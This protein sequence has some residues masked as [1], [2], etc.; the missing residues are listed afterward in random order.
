MPHAGQ[1]SRPLNVYSLM[2]YTFTLLLA[3]L[4]IPL[5]A[6]LNTELVGSL[7]YDVDVNDVWGYVAPDGTE[8]ALLGLYDG[9]A[10]IS[11]ADPADPVEVD[12]LQGQDSNWRD[13]KTY[14]DYAYVVADEGDAGLTVVDLRSL[15]DSISYTTQQ[16]T[17]PG[18]SRAFVRAH[19]LYIDQERG[20]LFTAGGDRNLNDGGILIFDVAANPLAPP[21]VAV[22]PDTYAH[23]VYVQ[24]G[25]MYASEIYRGR[26]AL[27]DVTDLGLVT[28]LG[29][30]LT[31]FSFTH[32]AWTTA[33]GRTVFTTDERANASVAAFD[34][35]NYG[36]IRLL[37]EYR[38]L[39]SLN[40]RTIPH[41][42][43][44]IDDF[45]S[46]S[47]YTDGLRVVD[48]SDPANLIEVAN[49]DT[50]PGADGGFNGAWGAYP[51]LPSGLTL[52]SDRATGL[53]VIDVAYQ[54]AARLVGT[55]TNAVT[56]APING[57]RVVILDAYLNEGYTD[58]LGSFA[59]GVVL[60]DTSRVRQDAPLVE[61]PR[62][63][64]RVRVTAPGFFADTV[65]VR[66]VSGQ[67][68]EQS[69]AL[70]PQILAATTLTLRDR[71]SDAPIGGG[72]VLLQRDTLRFAAQ[73]DNAAQVTLIDVP[74]QSYRA[75]ATAWG[76]R[77]LVLPE[78]EV[79]DLADT[80]L[81]LERGYEDSFV[82]DLGWS[83]RGD[84]AAGTWKRGPTGGV[85]DTAYLT[86]PVD[87]LAGDTIDAD[88]GR[89]VLLSPYIDLSDY[90]DE[91]VLSFTY[92]MMNE[93]P[94]DPADSLRVEL[95]GSSGV[96]WLAAYSSTG[97]GEWLRDSFELAGRVNFLDSLRLRVSVSDGGADGRV[98]AGFDDFLI[99]DRELTSPV[100]KTDADQMGVWVYPNPSAAH[101]TVEV[102]AG[103][104]DEQ[105]LEVY[106]VRGVRVERVVVATGSR[107]VD[108]GAALQRGG[109][110]VRLGGW[111]TRVVKH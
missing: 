41:N 64:Y 78:V 49:Y 17:V 50:W 36:D 19:N 21:L 27:Y 79:A 104:T 37:D 83:V 5:G 55:V 51:F 74:S 68:V 7:D 92:T 43:H 47:H 1:R 60:Q 45:L 57:A 96:L 106:D 6:Q 16:Y 71:K 9:V 20:L 94:F 33:D 88:S 12:R 35:T 111:V 98:E 53:Y 103:A 105:M 67:Q 52:V 32:N 65:M 62:N 101:F 34:L 13:M 24:D 58:A 110:V 44:V 30:A 15:P 102:P 54:R 86:E 81:Y 108:F 89:T 28:E 85:Q 23:D 40:T 84:A 63:T 91:A 77:A 93:G 11:L 95:I 22:G 61:M 8:Y 76:Y 2:K 97:G 26:I 48:A 18:F 82:S 29:E 80:V 3:A 75:T 39:S 72:H 56:G 87:S 90:T 100:V 42:V 99:L 38:P 31:P 10:V 109:Y 46:I 107:R 14:G 4:G 70:E 59:T 25:V 73:S 66:L 69:V